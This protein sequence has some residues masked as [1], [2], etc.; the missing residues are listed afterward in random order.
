MI[1]FF[2]EGKIKD[3]ELT[4][5]HSVDGE[6]FHSPLNTK[7]TSYMHIQ[8]S[9]CPSINSLFL[10]FVFFL[11]ANGFIMKLVIIVFVLLVS[12]KKKLGI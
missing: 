7:G 3:S 9:S 4:D 6:T 1:F 2:S 10:S 11:K 12:K 5:I 8:T